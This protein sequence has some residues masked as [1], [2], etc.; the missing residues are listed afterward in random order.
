MW[1]GLVHNHIVPFMGVAEGVI[2]H[3]ICMVTPWMR[4]GSVRGYI[5]ILR[6]KD[7]LKGGEYIATV[8]VWVSTSLTATE[9]RLILSPE[10][11]DEAI[12]A[13]KDSISLQPSS[14]DAHTSKTSLATEK[15]IRYLTEG[16]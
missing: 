15:R 2:P 13:W 12:Q 3:A 1:K 4:R 14:P 7:R 5:E 9:P 6:K 11:F 10:E 8:N 16:P